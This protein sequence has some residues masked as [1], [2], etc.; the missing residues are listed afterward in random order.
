VA[1]PPPQTME[2]APCGSERIEIFAVFPFGDVS[3][4]R[5]ANDFLPGIAQSRRL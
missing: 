2:D 1:P 3:L 4:F 5:L